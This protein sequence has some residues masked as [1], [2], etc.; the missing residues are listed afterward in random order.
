VRRWFV[1]V[2]PDSVAREYVGDTAA[3]A[4]YALADPGAR[5]RMARHLRAECAWIARMSRRPANVRRFLNP[6][7][8]AER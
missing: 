4:A 2:T 8:R 5:A 3:G 1:M 6:Y 7:P